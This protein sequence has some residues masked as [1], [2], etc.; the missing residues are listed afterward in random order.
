MPDST[1][2][3]QKKRASHAIDERLGLLR[4]LN[5]NHSRHKRRF[6]R[7]NPDPGSGPDFHN[8]PHS[9]DIAF[10]RSMCGQSRQTRLGSSKQDLG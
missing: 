8:Q 5:N 3:F 4:L 7:R 9:G 2:L 6:G 1:I 10:D